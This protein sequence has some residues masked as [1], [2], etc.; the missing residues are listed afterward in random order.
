MFGRVKRIWANTLKRELPH[1]AWGGPERILISGQQGS[2]FYY[3][4]IQTPFP[5]LV[6]GSVSDCGFSGLRSS[7]MVTVKVPWDGKQNWFSL[8][9]CVLLLHLQTS[10]E[11]CPG[12]G[13]FSFWS[14]LVQI[15]TYSVYKGRAKLPSCTKESTFPLSVNIII[16]LNYHSWSHL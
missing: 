10:W 12:A 4:V 6:L 5:G 14:M 11:L 3:L 2:S 7:L 15:L 1:V 8:V 9:L 16:F 13:P